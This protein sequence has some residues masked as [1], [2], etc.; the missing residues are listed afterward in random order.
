MAHLNWFLALGLM[1]IVSTSSYAT[2]GVSYYQTTG[3]NAFDSNTVSGSL[4]LPAGFYLGVSYNSYHSDN[5]SGTIKSY[6]GRLGRYATNSSW[7]LFGSET[8]EVNQYQEASAGAEFRVAILGRDSG[9][10]ELPLPAVNGYSPSISAPP[11]SHAAPRL[12]FTGGYTRDMFKDQG[13]DI[14]ENDLMGGLGFSLFKT[15]LSGTFTKSL[16]DSEL[17]GAINTEARRLSV[18]YAPTVIPGYPDY[19]YT[20]SIDQTLLPGWWVLGSYSHLKYKAGPD[21]LA[22]MYSAGT[23]IS[24]FHYVLLTVI[25]TRFV[26][27]TGS[28]DKQNFLTLGAGLHF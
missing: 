14:N 26:P 21:D 28:A 6:Y 25:Y 9:Q 2:A 24:L 1:G 18:G 8:P 3:S 20:A 23:G 5:S 15:Y 11:G 10:E 16:Y 27:A 19:A 17:N 4:D 12:D 22:D 13:E 7:E